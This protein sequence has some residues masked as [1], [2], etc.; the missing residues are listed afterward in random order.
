MAFR[1]KNTA[2]VFE[3]FLLRP[4]GSYE[5]KRGHTGK[6]ALDTTGKKKHVMIII[7]TVANHYPCYSCVPWVTEQ[8]VC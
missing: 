3:H 5:K 6:G 4:N 2:A 7:N 8:K 1:K